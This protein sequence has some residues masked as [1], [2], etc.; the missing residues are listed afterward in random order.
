MHV[1]SPNEIEIQISWGKQELH[2]TQE[3]VPKKTCHS[4]TH[5][6]N[7]FNGGMM[8]KYCTMADLLS[9]DTISLDFRLDRPLVH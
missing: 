3:G 9:A 8:V 5:V 7:L 6:R 4:D 2:T 1:R